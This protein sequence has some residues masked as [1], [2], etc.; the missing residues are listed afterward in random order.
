MVLDARYPEMEF[1]MQ[2]LPYEKLQNCEWSFCDIIPKDVEVMYVYGFSPKIQTLL[3]WI[4]EDCKRDLVFIEDDISVIH[5]MKLNGDDK[6]FDND[7]IHLRFR[8]KD[9]L[10]EKFVGDVAIDFPYNSIDVINLKNDE[11]VFA[12]LKKLLLQKSVVGD[13]AFSDMLNY[14]YLFNNIYHNIYRVCDSFSFV[15]WKN[16]FK[17]VPAILCGAG[18]SLATV[19]DKLLSLQD[20]ALI[21]A[22]GSTITALNSLNIVPHIGFA[23]DP[24][25]EEFNR[26]M[27][28]TSYETP[29]VF[30]TRVNKNI[31]HSHNGPLGYSVTGTGGFIEKWLEEKIGVED[32]KILEGLSDNAMS[33]TS[34]ALMTAIYFGCNPIIFAGVDL[35][36]VFGERYSNGVISSFESSLEENR[37]L[38][39]GML[40]EIDGKI[41]STQW[42]IESD[43]ISQVSKKFSDRDFIDG[44]G[45]GIGFDGIKHESDFEKY[46]TSIYDIKGIIHDMVQNTQMNISPSLLDEQILSFKYSLL[47]SKQ[48]IENILLELERKEYS[49]KMD[50]LEM[51]LEN[52]TAYQLALK[53][54]LT[55]WA[56]FTKKKYRHS[57]DD[58]NIFLIKISNYERLKFITDKYLSIL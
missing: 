36:Y 31:F 54:G 53:Q 16:S 39:A 23:F 14:H 33:V 44:T 26:L 15:K 17:N 6:L 18:P 37:C 46:L 52:E 12:E 21:L 28:H 11:I 1:L 10:L 51:D 45:C 20:R 42:I 22:G 7:Q 8:M 2:I 29:I 34:V 13:G 48:L 55:S 3:K 57:N 19:G 27:F 35:S 30:A 41:T 5:R 4:K 38:T 40:H 58:K 49:V 47:R 9:V 25:I 50:V 24:N 43:V 32:M 56:Y